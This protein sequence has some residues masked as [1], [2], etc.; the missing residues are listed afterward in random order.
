LLGADPNKGRAQCC[1]VPLHAAPPLVQCWLNDD[2]DRRP[3]TNSTTARVAITRLLLA[4]GAKV[5]TSYIDAVTALL[6]VDSTPDD[7]VAERSQLER[8]RRPL[9]LRTICASIV[10]KCLTSH[11]PNGVIKNTDSLPLPSTIKATIKLQD[12]GI[13][14][15]PQ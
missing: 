8:L 2:H 10:R 13:P 14:P 5:T 15:T 4:C 9:S 7:Q 11:E 1:H 6:G 3:G 12:I